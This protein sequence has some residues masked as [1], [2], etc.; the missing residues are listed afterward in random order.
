MNK[1]YGYI[2]I[3]TNNLNNK[4]YIRQHTKFDDKYLGSGIEYRGYYWSKEKKV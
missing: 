1:P 4:K 3:T 2:Y